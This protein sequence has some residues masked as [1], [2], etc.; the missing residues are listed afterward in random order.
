[1]SYVTVRKHL[2]INAVTAYAV[3]I[4]CRIFLD[5]F[6]RF[7][8]AVHYD[9]TLYLIFFIGCDH[10]VDPVFKRKSVWK[11]FQSFSSHHYYFSTCFL[12]K[13]L[14]ICRNTYQKLVVLAD[15]PVFICCYDNI[16][17]NFPLLILYCQF[18][19]G[20]QNHPHSLLAHNQIIAPQF[21]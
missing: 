10:N 20:G 12:T 1:M 6:Q 7:F 8:N 11:T 14:H 21:G 5:F 18:K 3:N 4:F 2:R 9:R 17:L 16:H 15:P 19:S 13:H